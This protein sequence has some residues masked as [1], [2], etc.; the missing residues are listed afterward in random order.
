VERT[1]EVRVEVT[2]DHGRT[3]RQFLAQDYTFSPEGATFQHEEPRLDVRP[4]THLNLTI[5][6]NKDGSGVATLT[7]LRLFARRV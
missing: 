5:I 7:S 2:T 1:Q 3:Y 6:P 4:I